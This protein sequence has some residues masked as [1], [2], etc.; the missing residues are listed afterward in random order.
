MAVLRVKFRL[1]LGFGPADALFAYFRNGFVARLVGFGFFVA[2][3]WQLHH[4]ELA[5]AAVFSVEL[6]DGMGGGG[7]AGE[8]V[9]DDVSLI[10]WNNSSELS[11]QY[12]WLL[13]APKI[14]ISFVPT[15]SKIG[16]QI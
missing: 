13:P 6:H 9:E 4:D 1:D 10:P 16:C 2:R 3:L 11:E 14:H 12:C 7:G 15:I 8:E 5:I